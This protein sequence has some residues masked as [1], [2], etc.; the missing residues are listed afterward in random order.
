VFSTIKTRDMILERGFT[1]PRKLRGEGVHG[2][3]NFEEHL[4]RLHYVSKTVFVTV[5]QVKGNS[6]YSE[7][8][9]GETDSY[10]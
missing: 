2:T 10:R 9:L 5:S 1:V 8:Q 6:I 3:R 7:G 4:C